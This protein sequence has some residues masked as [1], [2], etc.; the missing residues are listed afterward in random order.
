MDWQP[1][2]ADHAID[3]AAT[4]INFAAP[5]E[6]DTLDDVIIKVRQVAKSHHMTN[7]IEVTEPIEI[8]AKDGLPPK[9][10]ELDL[11]MQQP[12]RVVFRRMDIGNTLV[13]ELSISN[14]RM[15]LSTRKYRRW[16]DFYSVLIDATNAVA[17]TFDIRNNVKSVQLEFVDKFHSDKQRADHFEILAKDSPY[18]C[19]S[20]ASKTNSLHNHSGWFDYEGETTRKLTNV[21]IDVVESDAVNNSITTKSISVLTMARYEALDGSLAEPIERINELHVYLKKAFECIIT[22]EAAIRV[23]LNG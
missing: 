2:R 5:L 3:R 18:I 11:A 21:N 9:L 15:I 13:E 16:S 6:P 22:K 23:A 12:R 17:E 1:A 10:T 4:V 8:Q 19:A 7:R 14:Q 20:V